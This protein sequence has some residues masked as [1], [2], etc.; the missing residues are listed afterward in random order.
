LKWGVDGPN[1]VFTYGPGGQF[2]ATGSTGQNYWVDVVFNP[3]AVT[4]STIWPAAAT[5][6][7]PFYADR[8][9]ELGVK[10]RSDVAGS[11]TGVR[12]YKGGQNT[13]SHTGSLWSSSG[14]LLATGTFTNEMASGWQQLTFATPVTIA[15]NTTYIASYHTSTGFAVDVG[16]FITRG[17]DNA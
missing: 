11:V 6:A 13:G 3:G 5:P 16:Y 4:A 2:P 7:I 1:G 17:A 9:V 14:T 12:F 15:P 8:P 10:F